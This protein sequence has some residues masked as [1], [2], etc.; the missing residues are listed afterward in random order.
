MGMPTNC[1][2][3]WECG[4]FIPWRWWKEILWVIGCYSSFQF[5]RCWEVISFLFS[6]FGI[7]HL[8][9]WGGGSACL[10][11]I[12]PIRGRDEELCKDGEDLGKVRYFHRWGA[13][14]FLPARVDGEGHQKA[15]DCWG[16][17]FTECHPASIWQ[18][19]ATNLDVKRE[20]SHLM[21]SIVSITSYG[22]MLLCVGNTL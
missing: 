6:I 8:S 5:Q 17:W 7:G 22:C 2:S 3:L 4:L 14:E 19:W 9:I 15:I 18:W 10:Q 12:G 13:W 1:Y 21:F 16:I 20:L 11:S